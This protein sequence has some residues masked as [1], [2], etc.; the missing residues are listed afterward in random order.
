MATD[1]SLK[2]EEVVLTK[3]TLIEKLT[4]INIICDEVIQ[5]D[6]GL[7]IEETVNKVGFSIALIDTSASPFGYD[8]EFLAND[9][10]YNQSLNFRIDN[11][12]DS[13]EAIIRILVLVF[14]I[15]D[16][17]ESNLLFLLNDNECVYRIDG[18]LRINN[19]D[20]FWDRVEYRRF[21]ETR[22]Y[23]DM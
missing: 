11:D 21:I 10:K 9:F 22:E 2:C 16:S 1:C 18:I 6:K 23:K 20:G 7:K 8:S 3:E 12:W 5:L 15:I 19:E 14:E 4:K 13:I 17:T